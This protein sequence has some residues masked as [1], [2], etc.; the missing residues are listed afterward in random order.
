MLARPTGTIV[1]LTFSDS[2]NSTLKATDN[3]FYSPSEM[4]Q[5]DL[6]QAV[7]KTG[8]CKPQIELQDICGAVYRFIIS[9]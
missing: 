7:K 5:A 6:L 2:S 8:H 4:S 1:C 9:G 3:T